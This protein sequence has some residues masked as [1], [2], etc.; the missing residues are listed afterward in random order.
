MDRLLLAKRAMRS[1]FGSNFFAPSIALLVGGALSLMLMSIVSNQI[2]DEA[3][4]RFERQASDV[5]HVVNARISSYVDVIRGVRALFHTSSVVS[6]AEFHRYVTGLKLAENYPGFQNL[7]FAQFV[8]DE[9]KAVFESR[10]RQDTSLDSQGYPD[11]SITPAGRRRSYSV[12]LYQEPMASNASTFG[13]DLA[14]NPRVEAALEKSRDT[15]EL[16]S[17]GSLIHVKGSDEHVGLAMR[18]PVYRNDMPQSTVEQRRAAYAGSVGAGFNVRKLMQDVLDAEGLRR[19]RFQLYDR[20]PT[21]EASAALP[22]NKDNFLFDSDQLLDASNV[23]TDA[24]VPNGLLMTSLSMQVG[25]RRWELMFSARPEAMLNRVDASLPWIA[26]LGGL[27]CSVLL[28]WAFYAM[29]SSRTS[30][31]K[32]AK[33]MTRDLRENQENLAEAQRTAHLGSLTLNPADKNMHWSAE[34]YRIFGLDTG[35][36]RPHFDQFLSRIHEGDRARLETALENAISNGKRSSGEYRLSHLDGTVRWAQIIFQ[37]SRIST[38]ALLNGTIMDITERKQAMVLAEV[39]HRITQLVAS[40]ACPEKV[41][42]DVLETL[43]RGLDCLCAVFRTVDEHESRLVY[44]ASWCIDSMDLV[45]FLDRQ[46]EERISMDMGVAGRAWKHR[47]PI[48]SARFNAN[49]ESSHCEAFP[50]DVHSVFACPV[51]SDEKVFGLI[52]CFGM[53]QYQP[54]QGLQKMLLSISS[55]I[56][57][58]LQRKA[59]EKNL[60]HVAWHDSL[61]GLPNRSMFHQTLQQALVRHA[62]Y[63]EGLAVLFIDVDRFKVINDT[64]GHSAGDLLLIEFSRRLTEC[65]RESDSVARLGG[66]EFAVMIERFPGTDEVIAVVKKILESSAQPFCINGKEFR[67]TAS[68]GIAVAP[69]D[70]ADVET[71]LKNADVAMYRA[72][73]N[74]NSYQFYSPQMN[75]DS[76]KR[77][78]LESNLRLALDRNEMFLHY[79]PKLDLRTGEISGVEALLRWKHPQLGMVSPAEFIPL[80]EESGLIIEIGK[81]VLKMACRQN[82]EWQK[83]GLAPMRVAVNLSARQFRDEK[84]LQDISDILDDTG[85]ASDWLEIEVTESMVMHDAKHAIQI[86]QQLKLLGIRLSIDDFGTGYS[87]LAYLRHLPVDCVKIDRSFIKD[88]PNEADDMA[89]TTGI[90]GLAHCL[91]LEVVA[92]GIET[93][94]QLEFLKAN[95]CD[96]IQGYFFSKPLPVPELTSLLE[97]NCRKS[98]AADV[99]QQRPTF[100]PALA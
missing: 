96:E 4:L 59:A 75:K 89:I 41:I 81:W 38:G 80:A 17:S 45:P 16:I 28:S 2:D 10:A 37:A 46:R 9:D 62:R 23:A 3:Q 76:L 14:Y 77:F 92:E 5:H 22:R 12:L 91:R 39:E 52:E 11:F 7:N 56:S 99:E 55:Q 63:Q 35:N 84:L 86:L 15:G 42:P 47:L 69:E 33:A 60:H 26:L 82:V 31:V 30:A 100:E 65:L 18:M 25:G 27:L 24:A 98:L 34:T 78:T 79:Q 36:I 95:G 13:K 21:G 49:P 57:L 71:L 20:G 87:S 66:D 40:G 74:G 64:L 72:K 8:P 70:G 54:Y 85:L 97:R 61:T 50:S 67:T 48:V 51:T 93:A 88:I 94:N 43:C 58:Y 90:I 53:T 83:Q 44:N 29:T 19:M 32:I 6:R 73:V 1:F 68:I